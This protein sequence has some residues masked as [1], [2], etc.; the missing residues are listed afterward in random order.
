MYSPLCL[1]RKYLKTPM[2]FG[3]VQIVASASQA[4]M[5]AILGEVWRGYAA[6]D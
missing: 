3:H 2:A 6:L 1:K 5:A 4:L